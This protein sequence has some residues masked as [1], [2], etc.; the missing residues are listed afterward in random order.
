MTRKVCGAACNKKLTR[1]T[2][3][4]PPIKEGEELREILSRIDQGYSVTIERKSFSLQLFHYQMLPVKNY[5]LSSGCQM[6]MFNLSD[7]NLGTDLSAFLS[8]S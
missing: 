7:L 3:I 6:M 2:P 8:V 4:I 1:Q 5:F